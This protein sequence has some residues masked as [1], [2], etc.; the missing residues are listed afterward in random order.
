M[1][2]TV[3][4]TVTQACRTRLSHIVENIVQPDYGC[5]ERFGNFGQ[6]CRATLLRWSGE[7]SSIGR[8]GHPIIVKPSVIGLSIG[9]Q[10][11]FRNDKNSIQPTMDIRCRI[12]LQPSRPDDDIR[13]WWRYHRGS[14]RARRLLTDFDILRERRG[15]EG[16]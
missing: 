3:A 6:G 7:N 12:E 2:T 4:L 1:G 5:G 11:I 9:N 10:F 8:F 14:A 13:E 15:A 16:L